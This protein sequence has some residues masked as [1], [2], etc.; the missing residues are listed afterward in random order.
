LD[1]PAGRLDLSEER[2]RARFLSH[3]SVP[4]CKNQLG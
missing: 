3:D 2:L 1:L 4:L